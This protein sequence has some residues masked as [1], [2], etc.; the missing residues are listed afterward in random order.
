MNKIFLIIK[1]EYLSR[2]KKKSFIVMTFLVP[3]LFIGM[4]GLIGYLMVN[5]DEIGDKKNVNVVDESGV[6]A[7][8]LKN[9]SGIQF[10]YAKE[11]YA[12]AKSHLS[13]AEEDNQYLLH[14]PANAENVEL[15]SAKKP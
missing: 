13:K 12:E 9:K 3:L 6:F 11:T 14:I 2:V 7:G 4:Y 5:R 1:R 8:K 15:L 10:T